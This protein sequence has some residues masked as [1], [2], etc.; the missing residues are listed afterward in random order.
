MR[1]KALILIFA[2]VVLIG[3]ISFSVNAA[4]RIIEAGLRPIEDFFSGGWQ[5]Y[6]K[7]V[8][9]IVFFFLFFPAYLMGMKNVKAFGDKLTRTHMVFAFTAAFLSAFIITVSMRFDRVNLKYVALFLI[10]VLILFIMYTLLSKMGLEK[11][12]FWAFL[13]ALLLTALLLWLIWYLIQEGMPLG[14]LGR[15]SDVFARFGKEKVTKEPLGAGPPIGEEPEAGGGVTKQPI[16]AVKESKFANFFAKTP[17]WVFVIILIIIGSTLG[18]GSVGK[19]RGQGFFGGIK[20]FYAYPFSAH[21]LSLKHAKVNWELK[22]KLKKC[23]SDV[24]DILKDERLSEEERK[25]IEARLDE[26]ISTIDRIEKEWV[27]KRKDMLNGYKKN[28]EDL[29]NQKS[30]NTGGQSSSEASQNV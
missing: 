6:E 1:R 30:G 2:M 7:T 17:M 13:L 18:A 19:L 4:P 21:K 28:L 16:T 25:I 29:K 11:H 23:V 27:E 26:G 9:F 20:R 24:L 10:G 14:G 5:N 3:L 12:K 22:R 15:I 8:A